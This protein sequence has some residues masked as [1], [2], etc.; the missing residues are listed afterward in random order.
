MKV[1]LFRLEAR[2]CYDIGVFIPLGIKNFRACG[3]SQA[4][5]TRQCP[6]HDHLL[7]AG[8]HF[9]GFEQVP[10][11]AYNLF[12]SVQAGVGPEH[13][14]DERTFIIRRRCRFPFPLSGPP[15]EFL[16]FLQPSAHFS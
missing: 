12:N 8:R 16:K 15:E 14:L 11:L 2:L 10:I 13:Q 4:K 9:A 5:D 3:S 6:A 7:R 1:H